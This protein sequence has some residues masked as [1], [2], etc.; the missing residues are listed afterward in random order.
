MNTTR[1]HPGFCMTA[2][3]LA[4][5][6]AYAP[7]SAQ[8][9]KDDGQVAESSVTIGIGAIGGDSADRAQFGQY[10]GL[11]RHSAYGLLDFDYYRRNDQTG[12]LTRFQG[13]N[14]LGETREL[15]FLWKRQGDWKFSAEYG[16]LV[17]Y[18]PYTVNTGMQGI[19]GTAPQVIHLSGGPGTGTDVDLKTKRAGLGLGFAKFLAPDLQLEASVRSENKD[20]M[21]AFGRGVNCPSTSAPGCGF[22]TGVSPAFALL[23]VPEPINSNHTQVEARLNYATGKLR[24]SG[25]YYGSYYN[26]S[27][28]SMNTNVPGSLNNAVGTLQPLNPG[29]QAILG[30][31][32]ALW[33]D[34]EAHHLDVAGSYAFTPT[35]RATFKLGQ[36]HASQTQNYAAAGLSGAPAGLTNLGAKVDTTLAMLGITSRPM[37]KLSL[38][39]E[40]R[41]EDRDSKI[42]I[43]L[44]NVE[45]TSAYTNRNLSNTKLR[46]KLQAAYQFSSDYRGTLGAD[47]ESIDRGVFT[48]TSAVSGISAL[49]QKTDELGYRAELRRRMSEDVSGAISFV[50]SRRDGSNWLRDN[51]GTGVTEITNPSVDLATGSIFMPTLAD[52]RRE[53]IRLVANWQATKNLALQFSAEDGRDKFSTPGGY[54]LQ[55]TDM[56]LFSL[57]AD[58]ALSER[59]KFSGY[60]S[61]GTQTLNQGRYQ[62]YLMAYDNRSTAFGL[63]VSGKLASKIEVGG[64]VSWLEDRN[65]Y[66]Q[67]VDAAANPSTAALLAASGGLPDITFRKLELRAWGKYELSPMSAVRLDLLHYRVK[68]N[69]WAYGS[70][71]VPYVFSDNT[72]LWQSQL[73]SI[74]YLGLSYIHKWQ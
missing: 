33:P 38:L 26:N 60:V 51:S 62:G 67:G 36:S 48:A 74:T 12:M 43:A 34:N 56:S 6:A 42:P 65:V 25:G 8:D 55:R 21:R 7:V 41:W 16:E 10:N 40:M 9:K 19:G 32:M 58:Y 39:G 28:G 49:R 69:D 63:G 46:G 3:A 47:Y 54:G 27:F 29:V 45:G 14:L 31:A 61:H 66:A 13:L 11:R 59:W 18:D 72:T 57:D 1:R 70:G 73:Q 20:G 50:T 52:R 53:K 24:L 71:G 37:P 30:Q 35:T 23:F 64:G 4:I 68:F 5:L 22:T 15:N 2:L 17:R 44:Y